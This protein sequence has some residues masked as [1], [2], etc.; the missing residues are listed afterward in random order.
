MGKTKRKW[1][2]PKDV[3]GYDCVNIL[4]QKAINRVTYNICKRP[5]ASKRNRQRNGHKYVEVKKAGDAAYYAGKRE[6]IRERQ[7]EYREENKEKIQ[8]KDYATKKERL[9]ND[10]VY[11]LA[12]L[13]RTRIGNHLRGR[14]KKGGPTFKLIGCTPAEL[15][16][17][18]GD[19][20]G[21]VDHIFPLARHGTS[22]ADQRKAM[23]WS[24]LQMLTHEEN[25]WKNARLP[26]LAMARKVERWCW[27]EGITE[28][29]LVEK[30]DGWATSLRMH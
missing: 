29:D 16:A 30:Y 18:L 8:A 24:N 10:P 21:D 4:V 3:L 9:K 11:K 19:E 22:E 23:H 27:P 13:Q 12:C 28:A 2:R 7:A 26:T 17:Y 25:N 5:A 15:R 20:E 14:A 6:E 1:I